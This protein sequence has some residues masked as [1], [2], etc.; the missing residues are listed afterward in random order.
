MPALD[1]GI[2]QLMAALKETGQLENTL[3]VFTSDQG[4]AWG[5]HGFMHKLAPY[6]ANIRSPFI[7]SMPGTLPQGAVCKTPVGGADLVPT[8]FRFAGIEL[9][10]EMHGHD[11]TPLLQAS[12][13]PTGR[14][15]C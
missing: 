8:F 14:I 4:F 7:V 13:T 11:L 5:Q 2:G 10:W 15:R 1:E 6:D 3:V 9:P 12:R